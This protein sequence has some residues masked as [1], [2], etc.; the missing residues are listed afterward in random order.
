MAKVSKY[1]ST[2]GDTRFD[3]IASEI[4]F[5]LSL[6]GKESFQ[7]WFTQMGEDILNWFIRRVM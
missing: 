1:Q 5:P 4:Y 2:G 3:S 7:G 6:K